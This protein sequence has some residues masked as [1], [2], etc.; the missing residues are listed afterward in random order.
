MNDTWD[1]WQN[2]VEAAGATR[3]ERALNR[4]K[5]IINYKTMHSLSTH[6]VLINGIEQRITIINREEFNKKRIIALPDETIV[7]GGIVDWADNK[8]LITQIDSND[9]VN[10]AG[11]MEQ[12]NYELKWRDETGNIISKWCVVEDGTK[13][14]VGENPERIMTTGG[15]RFA[16]TIAKDEDTNKLKRGK[17]FLLYDPDC[18]DVLAFEI[19][20]P[21]TLFN[22]FEGVG[23]YRFILVETNL[24]D[25]DNK[26]LMIADYDNWDETVLPSE[27]ED[28]SESTEPK[29]IGVWL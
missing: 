14:L 24:T 16:V 8:W 2:Q 21:N 11:L 25:H 5:R 28:N 6:K 13:Y 1:V 12:C 17:R 20:K 9:E 7:H 18:Q 27:I 10:M 26:E 3:R 29:E 15:S 22:I 19:T 23:V 4:T